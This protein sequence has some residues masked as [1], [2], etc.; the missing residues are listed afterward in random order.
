MPG[1]W[2]NVFPVNL[3]ATSWRDLQV[4]L[5]ICFSSELEVA[6]VRRPAQQLMLDDV[7]GVSHFMVKHAAPF[8]RNL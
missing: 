7:D 1:S 4:S 6:P 8:E 5:A 2:S 3:V